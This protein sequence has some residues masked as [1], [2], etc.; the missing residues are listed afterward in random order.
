M[1]IT[2]E[3]ID[4]AGKTTLIRQILD[5]QDQDDGYMTDMNWADMT[6]YTHPFW[7]RLVEFL[8][9]TSE[10]KD[11]NQYSKITKAFLFLALH[12]PIGGF[13]GNERCT[14][15]DRYTDSTLAY[16]GYGEGV[17]LKLLSQMCS[18]ATEGMSPNLTILLDVDPKIAL[19]RKALQ[20]NDMPARDGTDLNQVTLEHLKFLTRVRN[21][22]LQIAKEN[23]KRFL[24]VDATLPQDEV[25]RQTWDEIGRRWNAYIAY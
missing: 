11:W 24:V 17:D 15:V 6:T 21:G 7:A 13:F 23:P 25:F 2:F 4:G 5:A 12:S 3:G 14:L 1:L 20:L 9:E 16:Q 22:Y 18:A 19:K 8:K 10:E